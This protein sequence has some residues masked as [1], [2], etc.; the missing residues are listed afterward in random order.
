MLLI[1]FWLIYIQD[2]ENI[3]LSDVDMRLTT[4]VTQL[5]IS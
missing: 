3:M 4:K 5:K 1:N 2:L